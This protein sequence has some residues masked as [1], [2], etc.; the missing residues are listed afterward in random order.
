[1]VGILITFVLARLWVQM[2]LLMI[3]GVYFN[4]DINAI[5]ISPLMGIA[6]YNSLP[7]TPWTVKL[8]LG[9]WNFVG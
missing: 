4:L 2:D 5:E 3:Y 6:W 8:K 1:M 7:N 9:T